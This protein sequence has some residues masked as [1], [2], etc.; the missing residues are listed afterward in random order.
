M[1]LI[2]SDRINFYKATV[3]RGM[4]SF[5]NVEIVEKFQIDRMPTID[6]ESLRPHGR[7]INIHDG[8]FICSCCKN[9]VNIVDM[10]SHPLMIGYLYCPY[11]GTKMEGGHNP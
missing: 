4:H 11:C 7:W 5:D 2:D 6:P 3:A 9:P 8:N 10:M 1:R